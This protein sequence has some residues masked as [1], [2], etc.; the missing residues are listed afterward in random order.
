MSPDVTFTAHNIRLDDGTYTNPELPYP[1]ETHPWLR[2]ASR[3]LNAVFPGDKSPYRLADLGCLEGGY[4]VEFA[5]MGFQ[6]LGIDVRDSNIAACRYV[7]ERT[8]LPNLEFAQ[9][10][11]W[12]L[13]KYGKF[14]A[15]FCC[16]LLY[17][18]DRPRKFLEL[19]ASVTRKLLIVQTHFAT[20]Q[21]NPKFPLSADLS[22]HEGLGGRWYIEFPD[23]AAFRKRNEEEYR[24]AS[25]G[26]RKSFWLR[27]E[28]LLQALSDAGFDMVMEQF[29]SFSPKIAESMLSGGYC[30][31]NRSTF[32]GIKA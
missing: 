25:W 7:K 8:N 10:D 32:V 6:V 17:H 24:W 4:S 20:D 21:P 22:E 27:R 12:N 13:A 28:Y 18:L 23:G 19:L 5:R 30:K 31:E 11:V 3:L 1:I 29:D 15:I 2:S 16:G 9:D 14:D 26:N